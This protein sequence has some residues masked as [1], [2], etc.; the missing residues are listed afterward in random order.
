[1]TMMVEAPSPTRFVV[2]ISMA[3]AIAMTSAVFGK[4]GFRADGCRKQLHWMDLVV[5][6]LD[7][8]SSSVVP[9]GD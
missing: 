5:V 2:P 4:L 1:M 3:V 9:I 6:H 7:R 8:G